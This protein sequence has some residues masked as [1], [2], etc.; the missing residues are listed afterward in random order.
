VAVSKKVD[1]KKVY[2]KIAAKRAKTM[3][4]RPR[5]LSRPQL[6]PERITERVAILQFL[7]K[8]ESSSP[9]TAKKPRELSSSQSAA[10][11][12]FTGQDLLRKFESH[13]SKIVTSC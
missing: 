3:S 2:K 12:C 11:L 8:I 5:D 1:E 4:A 10:F 7:N 6:P 13:N 9:R